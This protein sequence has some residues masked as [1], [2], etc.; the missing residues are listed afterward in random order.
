MTIKL[1]YIIIILYNMFNY[2]I[3]NGNYVGFHNKCR[4]YKLSRSIEINNSKSFEYPYTS[5]NETIKLREKK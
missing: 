4:T 5:C 3:S 1:I 2:S